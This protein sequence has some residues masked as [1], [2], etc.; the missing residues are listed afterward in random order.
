MAREGAEGGIVRLA[1]MEADEIGEQTELDAVAIVSPSPLPFT[2]SL[3]ASSGSHQRSLIHGLEPNSIPGTP[4]PP[5]AP[6]ASRKRA[7][8]APRTG[9]SA[10]IVMPLSG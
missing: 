9:L 1:K 7:T 6:Q 8:G 4:V 10:T 2:P 3:S 5:I